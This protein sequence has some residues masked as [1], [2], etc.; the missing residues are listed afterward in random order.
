MG[1]DFS[2]L[3]EFWPLYLK[4]LRL[5]LIISLITVLCGVLIGSILFLLKT[6]N[7]RIGKFKP[8]TLIASIYIEIIRGTPM[9]LQILIVYAG[10]KMFFGI[11]LSAFSS[12]VLAIALNSGAYVSEIVRAGIEAVDKGQ[13]EAAR[14]LGMSKSK[15]M[16]LVVIPQAIRN[17]LPA[18][19][20]EFVTVIKE[21]SMASVI[22]VGELIFVSKIVQ[23]RTYL[24]LEPLIVAAAFY[25]VITFTLGR[26]IAYIERRMKVSDSR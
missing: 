1:L 22:G 9:L 11:D 19:G 18:I 25:F 20:N 4:G 17:I 23:G 26:V 2:F 14:S 15:A 7:I 21:S 16:L 6:A 12:A 5:T 10:S 8:L 13:M 3:P 24:G